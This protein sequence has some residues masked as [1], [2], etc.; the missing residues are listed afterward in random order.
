MKPFIL[1]STLT[2]EQLNQHWQRYFPF[3][4]LKIYPNSIFS[5]EEVE[6]T[7]SLKQ[8]SQQAEE[9]T[10]LEVEPAMSVK[11]FE[12][13]FHDKFG[14]LAEVFRKSGYTWDDTDYTK[15]WTLRQQNLK[16]EELSV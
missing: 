3:L 13:A 16:G 10:E 8:I 1:T 15:S 12:T 5:N 9:S 6:E 4:K 14:L 11:E 2:P 7:L